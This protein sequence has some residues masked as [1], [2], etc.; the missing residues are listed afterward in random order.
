MKKNEFSPVSVSTEQAAVYV[1]TELHFVTVSYSLGRIIFYSI[2]DILYMN[3]W[4][5]KLNSIMNTEIERS[6]KRMQEGGIQPILFFTKRNKGRRGTD[7]LVVLQ[8]LP[9][10]SLHRFC[11]VQN[12][13]GA[14]IPIDSEKTTVS[15]KVTGLITIAD[16]YQINTNINLE[17][18]A[19]TSQL[20]RKINKMKKCI[21]LKT[22]VSDVKMPNGKYNQNSPLVLGAIVCLAA[23]VVCGIT[24]IYKKENVA[25]NIR[26]NSDQFINDLNIFSDEYNTGSR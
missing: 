9:R 17:Y 14:A 25:R 22:S 26:N 24:C 1:M 6:N 20:L 19:E 8:R 2:P 23:G 5:T 12:G 3:N 13:L 10:A 7:W 4:Q 15:E 18:P 16:F 21:N 11:S